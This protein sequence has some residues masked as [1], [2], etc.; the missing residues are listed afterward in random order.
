M[1]KY[2]SSYGCR[3]REFRTICQKTFEIALQRQ[4]TLPRRPPRRLLPT[5]AYI[6]WFTNECNPHVKIS[7][8]KVPEEAPQSNS[9]P[10][11]EPEPQNCNNQEEPEPDDF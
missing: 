8:Q 6:H 2:A 7:I 1:N 5:P 3:T 4:H 10:E 9:E 11:I